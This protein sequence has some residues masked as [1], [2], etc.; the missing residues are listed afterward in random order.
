MIQKCQTNL[1]SHL[2]P[3]LIPLSILNWQNS[4][5]RSGLQKTAGAPQKHRQ[6]KNEYSHK[7]NY[8]SQFERCS[9]IEL[10]L[11][12]VILTYIPISQS[13]QSDQQHHLQSQKQLPCALSIVTSSGLKPFNTAW[14]IL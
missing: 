8:H 11:M 13:T 3:I 10:K 1:C 6:E 12:H 2:T 4:A 7:H 5:S 9:N 14:N